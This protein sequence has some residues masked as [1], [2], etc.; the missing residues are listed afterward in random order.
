MVTFSSLK[1]GMTPNF[2][3]V[4]IKSNAFLSGGQFIRLIMENITQ[5]WDDV[6]L[7]SSPLRIRFPKICEICVSP[8]MSLA[9]C[10]QAEWQMNLRRMMGPAEVRE[11]EEL[12]TLR[13]GVEIGWEE[14]EISWGLSPSGG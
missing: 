5:F 2:G 13:S 6:W 10:A 4:F 8:G 12:Q 7:T 9:E 11:W 1:L 14:D 3:K